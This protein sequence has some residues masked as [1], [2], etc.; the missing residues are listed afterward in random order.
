M[1][2]M[3]NCLT[4]RSEG[5]PVRVVVV[6]DSALMRQ[7][8]ASVLDSDSGIKVVGTAP[9][10]LSARQMIKDLNPDVV[11]LDVEM[12]GMDG[13]TFLNKIMTLRPMPVIMVSSLTQKGAKTTLKALECG[14]I[15]FVAKPA[16][17]AQTGI[18]ELRTTLVAKVKAAANANV[19][20]TKQSQSELPLSPTIGDRSDIRLIAIG[21][22]TGGVVAVQSLL[23]ALP[24]DCPAVLIT[25]HMPPAFTKSFAARLNQ[26]SALTVTEATDGQLIQSG[27]AYVAPGDS[28][29]EVYTNQHGMVCRLRDAP[30]VSGHRPSVDVLFQSVAK[31]VG[32]YALGAI[33]TGMGRDGADGLLSMRQ[34]GSMTLGQSESSCVVYGMPKAAKEIGAVT[35][36]LSL[37]RIA[38]E[39]SLIN[40]V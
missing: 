38:H 8:L 9:D 18:K 24:S 7:M 5:R 30:P 1:Q 4:R 40:R 34:A 20:A 37:E 11:T 21:A 27:H 16:G 19:T 31:Q 14:A 6:D 25:Q 26:N 39:F 22:S 33:L 3:Q 35:T 13:L 36:E 2:A 28:H 29:L 32:Q 12:P 10:A 23:T 15:D 17:K